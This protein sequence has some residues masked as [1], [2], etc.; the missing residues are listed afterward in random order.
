VV[1]SSILWVR[2]A[3]CLYAV[4]LLHSILVLIRR[5][6]TF[7]DAALAAFRAGAVLQLV[8][9]TELSRAYGHIAVDN[10]YETLSLCAVLVAIVFLMV[11]RRYHFTS[12]S[13]A[14]FPLVFMMT[15]VAALERPG[16][17]LDRFARRR[18]VAGSARRAGRGGSCGT[19]ADRGGVGVLPAAGAA[20]QVEAS[21]HAA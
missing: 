17:N 6:Q 18:R 11:E 4:G 19:A 2:V 13:V 20:P 1:E 3:A 9:I 12:P 21:R 5:K 8:S 16:G 10:V 14:L 7:Y 15:L